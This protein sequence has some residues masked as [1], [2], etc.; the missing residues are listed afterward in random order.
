[1]I[2]LP[3]KLCR[4]RF[5]SKKY[6]I[7][8]KRVKLLNSKGLGHSN[9][10][11]SDITSIG[12]SSTS[13][14]PRE[15]NNNTLVHEPLEKNTLILFARTDREKEEWYNLFRKASA[16]KLQD[17]MEYLKK[18]RSQQM[19][20]TSHSV[21]S[22][23]SGSLAVDK[24]AF[25]VSNNKLIYKV[26]SKPDLTSATTSEAT[27]KNIQSGSGADTSEQLTT[28]TNALSTTR[29]TQTDNGLLYDSTVAFINTF[30]IR[31]FADFF[32]HKHWID[33]IQNKIQNKL[34]MIRVPYF[35]EELKITGLDLGTIVPI[36]KRSSEPWCD[37]K[38]LW[39]HLEIDYSG[40]KLN[41]LFV[42]VVVKLKD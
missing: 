8:L 19:L 12:H 1:M 26:N 22:T 14:T 37:E 27:N 33:R 30:M 40:G 20:S 18:K 4:K 29:D 9:S 39:V 17:S 2:I 5:W 16:K 7:C 25:E 11:A 21:T 23:T 13:T 38:G 31:A 41:T 3:A 6:P 24:I 34:S 36:I 35:M 10:I 15:E 32:T 42:V 28:E